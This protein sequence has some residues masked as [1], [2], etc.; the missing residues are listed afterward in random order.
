MDIRKYRIGQ[1]LSESNTVSDMRRKG[2]G[3]RMLWRVIVGVV[4]LML[5]VWLLLAAQAV[6][7][8]IDRWRRS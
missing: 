8:A 4:L 6:G 5:P 7:Q 3:Q 2:L 1:T